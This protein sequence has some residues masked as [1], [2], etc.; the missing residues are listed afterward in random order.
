MPGYAARGRARDVTDGDVV[1]VWGKMAAMTSEPSGA[2]FATEKPAESRRLR[3]R[4]RDR[5]IGG[6]AA[7]VAD[8]LNIDPLL[9]RAGFV[10]LMIFGGAGLALY[11]VAWLLIPEQGCD[12]PIVEDLLAP[13]GLRGHAGTAILVFLAVV[14]AGAWLSGYGPGQRFREVAL[15]GV[16][17][18]ALG[19]LLVRGSAMAWRPRSHVASAAATNPISALGP[20]P[21]QPIAPSGTSAGARRAEGRPRE[22]SPL[23]WYAL[24]AALVAVG[25]FAIVGTVPGVHVAPG[26]FFGVALVVVGLGLVVGAWWG[27]ARLLILLGLLIL[28]A[29]VAAAFVTVPLDGGVGDFEFR[30]QS[31]GEVHGEYRLASGDLRLDLSDLDARGTA[32]TVTASVG[33]GRLSVVVP[34]DA[35]VELDARVAGGGLRLFGNQQVGTGLGDRVERPNGVGARLVLHLE[36]GIGSVVVEAAGRGG[37]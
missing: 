24:A 17:I 29:A 27:R 31:P 12:D 21:H 14:V 1:D 33:V 7:G 4:A 36:A 15:L 3:R 13:V 16:A 8:H 37:G 34:D 30:P 10:G 26:Q 32:V 2:T 25:V 20:E 23:G 5:V 35:Q 11:V 18:I 28:P 6:V 9:V 19:G 22:S